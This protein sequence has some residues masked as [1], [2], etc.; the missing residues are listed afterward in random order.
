L[1][2]IQFV[3]WWIVC[4]HPLRLDLSGCIRV[5]RVSLCSLLFAPY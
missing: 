4:L 3:L 5:R 2:C 1:P